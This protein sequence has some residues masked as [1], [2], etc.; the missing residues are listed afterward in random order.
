VVKPSR[1]ATERSH[2][3]TIALEDGDNGTG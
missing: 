1:A 2:R 3:K